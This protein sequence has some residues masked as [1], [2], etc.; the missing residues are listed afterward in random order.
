MGKIERGEM[1]ERER[2]EDREKERETEGG[3]ARSHINRYNLDAYSN[4]SKQQLPQFPSE[5]LG[6][7]L[8]V[9]VNVPVLS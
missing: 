5:R 9:N 2:K 1:C 3:K 8:G 6:G 7:W 4:S